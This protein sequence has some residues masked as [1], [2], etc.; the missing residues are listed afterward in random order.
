MPR[1]SLWRPEYSKDYY[2]HDRQSREF[3]YVGGVGL[4]IHKYLGAET[5]PADST[6]PAQPT[7]AA[8]VSGIQDL[9]LLENRD[10]K[11]SKDL[12]ELRGIYNQNDVD[13]DLS[14]FGLFLANDTI[15][16][17][18]HINDMV[19]R[20]GRPLMSGDVIEFPNLKDPFALND[21]AKALKRF[22][23]IQD[24]S[25]SSEGYSPTWFPH[26]W[27]VK[28]GPLVDSQEFKDILGNG[29]NAD[30]L[31]N[32]LSNY[33]KV[34]EVNDA[35]IAQAEVDVPK[36]GYD[37]SMFWINPTTDTGEPDVTDNN[38]GTPTVAGSFVKGHTYKIVSPGTTNFVSIGAPAT[39]SVIG[40]IDNGS[41]LAGTTLTVSSVAS[42]AIGV[43]TYLTS[44]LLTGSQVVAGTYVTALGTGTGGIGTYTVSTSQLVAAGTVVK[45]IIS[46]IIF[47]ATGAGSGTGTALETTLYGTPRGQG[48]T[49]GYLVSDA[50]APNGAAMGFGTSFPA[51]PTTGYFFKRTDFLP[52]ILFRWTGSVWSHYETEQRV[53]LTNNAQRQTLKGSFVNNTNTHVAD[54]GETVTQRQ[55]LNDLLKP[56]AD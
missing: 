43:G 52:A 49:D 36:S 1:L 12:Y 13:F 34:K 47:E 14:Q 18:F 10:R 8:S 20:I 9:L 55:N 44:G 22:Y 29:S 40:K 3:F 28:V 6:G 15:F 16:V 2:W 48:Y 50:I 38:D 53:T 24:A 7:D 4:I 31:F 11:Y 35:V 21:V 33:N 23:V 26:V 39:A 25:R 42:G 17:N 41:G 51:N 19:E 54:S 32:H 30:D 46:D 56:Q 37:T 45:G 5:D 27:R